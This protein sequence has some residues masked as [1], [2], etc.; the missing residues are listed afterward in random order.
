[1]NKNRIKILTGILL[2]VV[3]TILCYKDYFGNV[4]Y[5]WDDY[6]S[7]SSGGAGSFWDNA[8]GLTDWL[9]TGQARYQPF[10]LTLLSFFTHIFPEELSFIYNFGLHLIIVILLFLLIRKFQVDDFIA[11]IISLFFSIIGQSR[12]MECS[13]VMI[14]GSGLVT[15]LIIL[16]M[17]FLIFAME[18]TS[19]KKYALLGLSYLSYLALIFSY[20]TAFP[21][22]L[23]IIFTFIMFNKIY[24]SKSIFQDYREYLILMPYAVFLLLFYIFFARRHSGY[25]GTTIVLSWDILIRFGYYIKSHFFGFFNNFKP[26]RQPVVLISSVIL[27]YFSIF[28]YLFKF[29]HYGKPGIPKFDRKHFIYIFLFGFVWYFSSVMLFTLSKWG[30][31]LSSL[32]NHHLYLMTAGF[33]VAF[34]SLLLYFQNIF[35]ARFQ[36]NV[37]K[38]MLVIVFP[39]VIVTSINYH[40]DYAHESSKK[41]PPLMNVKKHIKNNVDIDSVDAVIVKNLFKPLGLGYYS[42]SDFDGA[43]LQWLGFKKH[44]NSGDIIVSTRDNRIIFK[45]PISFYGHINRSREIP[46][47][48]KRAA[49]FYYSSSKRELLDYHNT[50][51]FEK[52]INIYQTDQ[53]FFDTKNIGKKRTIEA[54]LFHRE[55]PK[56]LRINFKSSKITDNIVLSLNHEQISRAYFSK[57]SIFIDL[58]KLNGLSNYFFLSLSSLKDFNLKDD[59]KSIGFA[60]KPEGIIHSI[61]ENKLWNSSDQK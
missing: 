26:L 50:I 42:I 15:L 40:N 12:L 39:F 43:L 34:I 48:N 45:G 25:A 29:E 17:I 20:E 30:S 47:D 32:M 33:T 19:W 9:D 2:L 59:I 24:K 52:G 57:N 51:D 61:K 58:S 11:F 14:G 7:L 60:S 41:I 27:Y 5:M 37:K 18:S 35:P 23:I 4:W 31:R 53:V 49:F 38:V 56:F 46:V 3:F 10:R 21:L 22:L 1:M 54:I 13:S 28:I 55:N 44:I 36:E 6:V 8:M 16:S